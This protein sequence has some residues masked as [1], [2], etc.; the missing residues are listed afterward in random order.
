MPGDANHGRLRPMRLFTFGRAPRAS[1]PPPSDAPDWQ[2]CRPAWIDG[3]LARALA[4]PTGGWYALDATRAFGAR[5][6]RY[7]VAGLTLAVWRGEA[8]WRAGPDA[9]PHLGAS[10]A[11]GRV[12][13]GQVVCPWHG[14]ALGDGAHGK[15]RPFAVHDD[16]VLV[17]VQLP[18]EAPTAAPVLAPR[19]PRALDAVVRVEAA[20]EPE[21]VLANR[22]DPWHGVHFHPHSFGRLRVL[23]QA[24][25]AITV[26]VVYRV[27]GA[28]GVEVDARFHCPDARTIVMT[29]VDGEGVGSVVETHATPLG[30]GRT[31]ILEATL[32]TT[33]RAPFLASEAAGRLL[34]P[35]VRRA[36]ARLWHDD[37]AYA[38][39]RYAVR[40]GAG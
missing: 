13:R 27:L 31:A 37:A 3:A 40:R 14:L 24:D 4:R 18:G 16:G 23:D 26:R 36:A 5:P 33:E 32:A 39:R 19:P 20:C 34:R 6:R 9:C 29:I 30:P 21:D 35:L 1:A 15:W 8:G 10:L 28:L 22:L 12:E 38:E 25:D 11:C 7:E 17:W 2:Q